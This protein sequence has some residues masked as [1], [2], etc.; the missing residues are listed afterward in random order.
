MPVLQDFEPIIIHF[1]VTQYKN[2]QNK[3]ILA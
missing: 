3:T 1:S 2:E